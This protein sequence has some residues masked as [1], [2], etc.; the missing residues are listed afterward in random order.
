MIDLLISLNSSGSDTGM[1]APYPSR[2]PEGA[3]RNSYG[4][5]PRSSS[6][7]G[8]F[9]G[10]DRGP[11]VGD[12]SATTS[13]NANS[14]NNSAKNYINGTSSATLPYARCTYR[15]HPDLEDLLSALDPTVSLDELS[16]VLEQPLR[17]V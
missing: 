12:V 1:T 8:G 17:E 11:A 5:T 7:K 14:S 6:S 10:G 16:V 13:D 15:M 9:F 2:G 4:E 3:R